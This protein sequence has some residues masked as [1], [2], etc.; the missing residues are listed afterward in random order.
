MRKFIWAGNHV[1]AMAQSHLR[2]R[3]FDNRPFVGGNGHINWKVGDSSAMKTGF[4]K[5]YAK[6]ED[7]VEDESSGGRS[8]RNF[9]YDQN[10]FRLSCIQD[11]RRVIEVTWLSVDHFQIRYGSYPVS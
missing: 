10:L 9:H 7:V 6:G 4:V 3:N 1:S 2:H 11:I 8:Y 5:R